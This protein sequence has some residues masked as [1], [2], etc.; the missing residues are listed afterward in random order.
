MPCPPIF[1]RRFV[2]NVE[3]LG[4]HVCGERVIE[5]SASQAVLIVWG[6]LHT[7]I[8]AAALDRR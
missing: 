4:A 3:K 7:R 2:K 8:I 1:R 6:G 5:K